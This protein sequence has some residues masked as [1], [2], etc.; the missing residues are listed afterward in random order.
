M[1]VFV[2]SLENFVEKNK[3]E[4]GLKFLIIGTTIRE[5]LEHVTLTLNKKRRTFS[6]TFDKDQDPAVDT[7]DEEDKKEDAS[8]QFESTQKKKVLE[9]QQH[10]ERYVNTLPVFAFNNAKYDLILIKPY[11]I[12]LLLNEKEI[13]PTVIKKRTIMYLS[14]L[15]TFISQISWISLEVQLASILSW[16][17][18]GPVRRK[19]S[20][21][22][23]WFD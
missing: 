6:P 22:F 5:K 17:H 23:E 10:F 2:Y 19:V 18:I 13:K 3:L 7:E 16:K 21:P 12:R 4:I 1:S 14:S 11:F 20:L 8:T 9:L 15:E